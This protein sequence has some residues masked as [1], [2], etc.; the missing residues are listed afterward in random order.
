MQRQATRRAKATV[1]K[2]SR[3]PALTKPWQNRGIR[4]GQACTLVRLPG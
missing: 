2:E 3:R 4:S 1:I